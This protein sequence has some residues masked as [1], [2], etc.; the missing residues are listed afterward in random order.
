MQI[1]RKKTKPYSGKKNQE[2]RR[3]VQ[4]NEKLILPRALLK[5]APLLASYCLELMQK[6][7]IIQIGNIC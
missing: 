6:P 2:I 1:F 7:K 5:P 4:T 3:G